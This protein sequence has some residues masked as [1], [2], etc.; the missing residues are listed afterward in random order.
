VSAVE[1]INI[2]LA[3]VGVHGVSLHCVVDTLLSTL[4]LTLSTT[5]C[6]ADEK[7]FYAIINLWITLG[8]LRGFIVVICGVVFHRQMTTGK[9]GE[10]SGFEG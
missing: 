10:R 7:S 5:K 2:N 4:K 6:V 3:V 1:Q 9:T 8:R